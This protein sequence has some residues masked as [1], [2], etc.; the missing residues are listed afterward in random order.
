[1]TDNSLQILTSSYNNEDL[2]ASDLVDLV[3]FWA[4]KSPEKVLYYLL[5]DGENETERITYGQFRQKVIS[6]ASTIQTK[7]AKGDRVLLLFPTGIDFICSLFGCFYAGVIGVPTYPP[8][9]NRMFSRFQG[10]IQD[11]SPACILCTSKIH[12]IIHNNFADEDCLKGVEFIIHE[13]ITNESSNRWEKPVINPE[14]IAILQYTSGSTGRP[15]GVMVS[16]DNIIRNSQFIK[17]AFGHSEH[18]VGANWLP[19]F[20]DM[21]LIGTLMQFIYSGGSN[22]IIPPN[23][24]LMRPH[25]WLKAITRF[26]ATTVGGP[27]FALDYCVD[28]VNEEQ[29][30]EIDLSTVNPFFCGSEPIRKASLEKFT[31]YF[32]ECGSSSSLP[33]VT[34]KV[35]SAR[36]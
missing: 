22:V 1:M 9:K 33:P 20:H 16:H 10:I 35:D 17:V 11:A 36:P 7:A 6:I 27:N 5:D 19:G 29:K 26:K 2:P 15:R 24:F 23:E 31:R 12:D 3:E 34:I 4:G 14:D 30:N 32:S 25:N 21:G 8:R 18:L 28:R 13:N